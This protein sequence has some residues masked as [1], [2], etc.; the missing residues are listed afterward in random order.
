ME[1]LFVLMSDILWASGKAI[2]KKWG[3]IGI[4]IAILIFVC[5]LIWYYISKQ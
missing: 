4:R 5:L 1:D 2:Y 3:N